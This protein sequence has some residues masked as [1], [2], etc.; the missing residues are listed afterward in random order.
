M[1]VVR[2]RMDKEKRIQ[3]KGVHVNKDKKARD[4]KMLMWGIVFSSKGT[5]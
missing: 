2:Q 5:T 1:G 4:W 3:H